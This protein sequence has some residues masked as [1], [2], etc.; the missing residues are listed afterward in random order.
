MARRNAQKCKRKDVG[1]VNIVAN[2]DTRMQS[3]SLSPG[4]RIR[5]MSWASGGISF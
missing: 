4:K 3:P 2:C 5:G 1:R